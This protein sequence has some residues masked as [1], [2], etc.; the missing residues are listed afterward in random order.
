MRFVA[1]VVQRVRAVW[2]A[3]RVLGIRLNAMDW[4]EGGLMIEDTVAIVHRLK[5]AGCDYVCL[6]AGAI[7]ETSRIPAAPGYLVP[8]ASR[9]KKETAMTTFVT[10][11][12]VEPRQA[13]KIIGDGHTDMVVIGRAFL[14]DPRWVWHAAQTLGVDFAYPMQYLQARSAVWNR[15]ALTH[16]ACESATG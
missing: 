11:M 9:V 2:P 5:E 1:E 6:S 8:Y 7:S 14:D 16:Q 4:V 15:A 12:I 10:G 3:E 13:E